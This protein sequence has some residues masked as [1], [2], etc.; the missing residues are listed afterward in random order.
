MVRPIR[1]EN[2]TV[3]L[4]TSDKYSTELQMFWCP[5]CRNA[6]TQYNNS[7]IVEIIAGKPPTLK[8][9]VVVVQCRND[10]CRR[11]FHFIG[12]AESEL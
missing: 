9:P 2:I 8:K 4:N 11:V 10:Q 3:F 12:I 6:V 1:K 7:E 5:F